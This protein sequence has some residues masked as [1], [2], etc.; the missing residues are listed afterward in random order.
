MANSGRF[1]IVGLSD[2][3]VDHFAAAVVGKLDD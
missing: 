2:D 3:N 1:N